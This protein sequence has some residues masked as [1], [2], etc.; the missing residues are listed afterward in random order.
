LQVSND[1]NYHR[2]QY[3]HNRNYDPIHGRW[4][5]R[6]PLG[7]RPDA[8]RGTIDP[9]T[10][11]TDGMNGYE[12][13]RSRPNVMV[14]SYGQLSLQGC[15][16]ALSAV[17]VDLIG[18][19]TGANPR[20]PDKSDQFSHCYH[21]CRLTCGCGAALSFFLGTIR[22]SLQ[23]FGD[24]KGSLRDM[25][26]NADGVSCGRQ[27]CCDQSGYCVRCCNNVLSVSR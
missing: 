3:N 14:D 20:F 13:V 5:E 22:E 9:P 23:Q 2:N 1:A 4:R 24:Y 15:K 17:V 18:N 25:I 8:P 21:S 6:D 7:L 11:Y 12:Y 26:S 27:C 19:M 16:D 10:Q